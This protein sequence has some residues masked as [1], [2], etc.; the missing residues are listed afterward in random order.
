MESRMKNYTVI[1]LA[2]LLTVGARVAAQDAL[3]LTQLAGELCSQNRL[4]EASREAEKAISDPVEMKVAQSWYI[5]GFIY[6]ELYKDQES[7]MRESPFREKAIQYLQNALTLDKN[8]ENTQNAK[9]AVRYLAISYFNDA[10][11]RSKEITAATADEPE[12]LYQKF[13]HCM[14]LVNVQTDF[15]EYDKQIFKSLGQAHY[16]MW[17]QNTSASGIAARS[18]DYFQR[19]LILDE[20]DCEA[21]FNLVIIYYNQGVHKIR[22]LDLQSDLN[23]LIASQ[24]LAIRFFNKAL[25]Y[26]QDCFDSCPSRVEYYKGL[27]FCNRA[28]GKEE[29]YL[30]LKAQLESLIQSGQLKEKK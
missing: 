15:T 20:S 9:A 8:G 4:I 6:K 17:E 29:E 16:R 5:A 24:E 3:P 25:P 12:A 10:L 11:K 18:A 14:R 21:K 27:M 7:E 2:F 23:D 13:R 28:L 22:S 30:R 1:F 19:V 26:A